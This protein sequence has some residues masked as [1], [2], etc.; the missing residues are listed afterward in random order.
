MEEQ[1]KGCDVGLKSKLEEIQVGRV[2]E[3]EPATGKVGGDEVREVVRVDGVQI[4]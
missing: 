1:V 4:M 2:A 3:I